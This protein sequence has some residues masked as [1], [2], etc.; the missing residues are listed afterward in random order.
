QATMSPLGSSP[1][2]RALAVLP[3]AARIEQFRRSDVRDAVLREVGEQP[4]RYAWSRIFVLGDPPDYEPAPETSIE[5]MAERAG[6]APEALAYDL[7]LGDDGRALLYSPLLN[8]AAGDLDAVREMLTHEH[9][10]VGLADG[11]AH[12]GTICDASFPTTMLT[13]WVR[14]RSR[15]ARLGLAQAV[16]KQTSKTAAMI[17]LLD[18]GVLAPGLRADINV[19][20]LDNLTLHPPTISFDL[21]AGGKRLL[22]R[23]DGYLHTLVAGQE[24]YT[25]GEHTGA[26]PGRL[27]RGARPVPTGA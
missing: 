23:A 27:V 1:T 4:N 9:S 22:Q 26:L 25:N 10:V 3:F 12:V 15:G 8:Y 21:P 5:A 19:I 24:T 18:R 2:A 11:G 6:V 20:D 16:A 14:D 13:H 17:G 7:L